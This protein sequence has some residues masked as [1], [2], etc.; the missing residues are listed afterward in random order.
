MIARGRARIGV[1]AGHARELAGAA[2]R[3][4][5]AHRAGRFVIELVRSTGRND[6]P[7]VAAEMAFRFT[8]AL[9]PLLLLLVAIAGA[10]QQLTHR[11]LAA[12]LIAGLGHVV[13]QQVIDPL[14]SIATQALAENPLGIGV[15]GLLGALWGGSGA[16]RTLMKGLNRAYGADGRSFWGQQVVAIVAT[17]LLPVLVVGGIGVF[18]VTGDFV[19][20]IGDLVGAS[21]ATVAL[22]RGFRWPLVLLS[23]TGTLWLVYRFL[24]HVRQGWVGSL[25]GAVVATL[26]WLALAR[27]FEF[28]VQH[29]AGIPATVGSLGLGMVILAWL[30]AIG[31]VLLLGAE[32][33]AATLRSARPDETLPA[34]TKTPGP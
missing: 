10:A 11:D 8:F 27:G 33:N 6:L 12:E 15:V 29:L 31:L 1:M 14:Q 25:P 26:G 30:Y 19:G 9:A 5:R 16:A 22:W 20:P 13:P 3:R 21:S 17:I 23:V 34:G 2:G 18:L 28:Y 32:V 4:L 24:P 7:G